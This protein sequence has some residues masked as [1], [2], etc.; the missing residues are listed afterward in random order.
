MCLCRGLRVAARRRDGGACRQTV[1]YRIR[2]DVQM[3]VSVA[4]TRLDLEQD[5]QPI[6]D[7]RAH[8]SAMLDQV[9]ETGRPIVLTQRG[10]SAAVLVDVQCWQR[11]QDENETLRE[12]LQGRA[13]L[14]AGQGIP[15]EEIEQELRNRFGG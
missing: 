4:R 7:F 10:R 14:R 13:E 2:L 11:L 6:S 15:H 12:V 1:R 3:E 9:R 5:V 8:A